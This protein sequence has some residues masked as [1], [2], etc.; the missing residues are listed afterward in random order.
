MK[1]WR[2]IGRT[3]R[4]V[5]ESTEEEGIPREARWRGRPKQIWKMTVLEEVGKCGENGGEVKNL[6]GNTVRWKCFASALCYLWNGRIYYYYYYY[7]TT[8]NCTQYCPTWVFLPFVH[9]VKFLICLVCIVDS[10]K[11]SCV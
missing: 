10:F 6:A 1:K 3:L 7:T 2:K 5:D 9:V 11:L 4:K 8:R